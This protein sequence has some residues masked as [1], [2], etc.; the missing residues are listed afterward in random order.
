MIP[1]KLFPLAW[2]SKRV[3]RCVALAAAILTPTGVLAACSSPATSASSGSSSGSSGGSSGTLTVGLPAAPDAL[4]PT[5]A[6]SLYGR[7]VFANMCQKLYDINSHLGLV[8]QLAA[9]LPTISNNGHTYTI[10]LRSGLKF[11]DGTPL[12]AAAVKTTLDWYLTDPLS[13]RASELTGLKSVSVTGPLTVQLHLSAPFAPLTSILAD[14]SGMILSPTD[15]HKLGKNFAQHPV[16]VG[17]FQFSSRP[18]SDEIV[19]T[20]SPYWS[21]KAGVHLQKLVF[22]VIT[23]PSA[24][25]ADLQSGDIQVAYGLAPQDVATIEHNSA[26]RVVAQ[27]SLG[28]EG[29]YVNTGNVHGALKPAGHVS[30]PFAEHPQLREAFELSLNREEINK[31]VFDGLYTPGCTPIP[32]DSP[33]AVHITCPGQ[34]IAEAKKL[35]TESGMKPPVHVSLMLDNDPLELQLGTVIQTMAKQAGF[36]VTLQPTE[37]TTELSKGEAGQFEMMQL[38]WSGRVDPD[39]NIYNDW[40]PG[41]ALNYTGAD[42]PQLNKMLLQARTTLDTATRHTLYTKIVQTLENLRNIIYLWYDK[43]ELGLRKNVSG[44]SFYPDT[45][46]RLASARVGG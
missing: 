24:M 38:G 13:E 40:Y 23:D 32:P 45:L 44:V 42:Y 41:S 19:L 29:L 4:D 22:Q 12:T 7:I 34:N 11:N 43:V 31:A 36:Q 39:Q 6:S 14:R 3:L 10:R 8:P 26:T 17:P 15:L 46:L 28:Y 25:S 30:N 18:S 21:G 35:I 27:N 16:C 33:W 9:A 2:P 20:K 1:A 5:T 37:F